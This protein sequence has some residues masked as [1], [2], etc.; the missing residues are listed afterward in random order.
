MLLEH[1]AL[2]ELPRVS[3]DRPAPTHYRAIRAARQPHQ[4]STLEATVQALTLLE[5]PSFDGAPLLDAFGRFVT[6]LAA[7]QQAQ[8]SASAASVRP[9]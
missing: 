2:A 9:P 1:R 3:L 6:G 8:V 4:V 5:G 7:R